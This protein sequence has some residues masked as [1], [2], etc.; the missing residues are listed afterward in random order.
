MGLVIAHEHSVPDEGGNNRRIVAEAGQDIDGPD[1]R[2]PSVYE[3]AGGSEAFERLTEVFYRRHV[4]ADE[5]L[6]PV[7]AR[8]PDDHPHHVALWLAEVFGGPAEYSEEHGGY[9]HMVGM[10]IGLALTEP[11]RARW[12]QLIGL[13]ADDAGLPTDPEFRSAFMAYVEWGTRVALL[14][15]QPGADPPRQAPMPHWGWGEAPPYQ[16]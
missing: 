9:A 3:W 11:Q 14:N 1:G 13:A 6:G 15:S 4:L 10:H 2:V 16:P 7:F 12:V 5:I 8:M